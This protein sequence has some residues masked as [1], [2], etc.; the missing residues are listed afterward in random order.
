MLIILNEE[1]LKNSLKEKLVLK[2]YS[3]YL[4]LVANAYEQAPD[5]EQD[6]VKHWN[7]LRSSNYRFFKILL[8]KIDVV[9]VTEN[10]S[11]TGNIKI[12]GQTFPIEYLEGGQPYA[13]Q[14][15]MKNEVVTIRKIRINI[16]YS[17]HP[18]FSVADNIVMRTVHDYIVH[19]LGNHDFGGKGEIASFNRH[20]KLAS[21]A[22]IPALFTEVVGQA[23]FAVVKGGFPVQKITLLKGFD[24]YNVGEI[25]DENYV[26][27]DKTLVHKSELDDKGNIK[28]KKQI[29][30]DE[31]VAVTGTSY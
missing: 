11:S 19:I 31:P 17:E 6:A 25:D 5:F 3:T 30:H 18:V 20:A 27:V 2:D 9:F 8:S 21:K 1:T 15:E 22:A 23:A 12:M 10:K 13:T 24:Y 7:A 26:I 28:N 16:D 29:T 4:E 14:S